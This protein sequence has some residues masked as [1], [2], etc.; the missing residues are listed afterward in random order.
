MP[1]LIFKNSESSLDNTIG[2]EAEYAINAG[3]TVGVC[4]GCTVISR[5]AILL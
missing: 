2:A 1:I 5:E 3:K 4:N